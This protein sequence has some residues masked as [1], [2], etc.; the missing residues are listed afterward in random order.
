M[1]EEQQSKR[2]KREAKL[3]M[4]EETLDLT[5]AEMDARIAKLNKDGLHANIRATKLLALKANLRDVQRVQDYSRSDSSPEIYV[6]ITLAG[7]LVAGF[8]TD[9]IGIHSIFG[10]FFFGLVIPKEGPFAALLNEKI[11][12]FVTILMLSLYFTTSGLKTNIDSIY[13][14][15][16]SGLLM[17]VIMTAC[18]GKILGTFCVAYL[19]KMSVQKSLTLGFLMNTK[20]LVELIVLNI[21]KD[22]KVLNEET[23][24]IMVLMALF[25]T[26]ITTPIVMALHK[27]ARNP[28]PYK[29]RMLY[30]PNEKESIDL[31]LRL[32]ACVHG[33]PNVHAIINLV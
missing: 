23:F 5:K 19:H 2:A 31:E 32:L 9:A 10:G 14:A 25:T 4:M 13:D 1:M 16:S 15:L 22:R 18:A 20:G 7:V 6:A 24:A 11:E 30:M 29:R 27:P 21:G 28:I 26:F 12:D 8:V 3:R 17:L 33:M